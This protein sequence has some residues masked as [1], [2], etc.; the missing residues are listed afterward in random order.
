MKIQKHLTIEDTIK[1]Q[2]QEPKWMT[3]IQEEDSSYKVKLIL[4]TD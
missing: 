3:Y 4:I 1:K 2:Y